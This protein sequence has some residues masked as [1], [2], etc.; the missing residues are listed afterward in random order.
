MEHLWSATW[1]DGGQFDTEPKIKL[2]RTEALELG[3]NNHEGPVH[4]VI[5]HNR[6]ECW[7]L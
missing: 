6:L 3:T 7:N 2:M 5:S 1:K 4:D